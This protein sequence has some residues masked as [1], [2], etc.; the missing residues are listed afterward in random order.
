VQH[1]PQPGLLFLL[2]LRLYND[3]ISSLPFGLPNSP[4]YNNN[5]NN[6][7]PSFFLGLTD[8][9][10]SYFNLKGIR[11][12]KLVSGRP[13]PSE[14]GRRKVQG[15]ERTVQVTGIKALPFSCWDP[16]RSLQSGRNNPQLPEG[17][18]GRSGLVV[19]SGRG[20]EADHK[21]LHS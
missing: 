9:N 10:L 6:N 7:K 12:S 19:V 8:T 5:N 17:R 1:T 21:S 3:T 18:E 14:I 4:R 11:R 16:P 20:L 13:E 2:F 15:L